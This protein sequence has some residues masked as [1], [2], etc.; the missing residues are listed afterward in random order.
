MSSL[1]QNK[2]DRYAK[3]LIDNNFQ[4]HSYEDI[5]PVIF[6]VTL[7]KNGWSEQKT[8]VVENDLF[9][10]TGCLFTVDI[11]SIEG[12]IQWIGSNMEI[13][14][15][16]DGEAEFIYSATDP[17]ADIT[18]QVK[19]E[20]ITNEKVEKTSDVVVAVGEVSGISGEYDSP[21]SFSDI[22]SYLLE[23]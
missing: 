7:S 2:K 13:S 15:V 19:K 1:I 12:R 8:Q 17:T 18:I 20:R 21:I 11:I 14:A 4:V 6:D 3:G 9:E 10:A 16:R 23:G 5:V 22:T